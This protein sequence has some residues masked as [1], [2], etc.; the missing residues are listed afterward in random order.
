MESN[1]NVSS[2]SDNACKDFLLFAFCTFSDTF[3]LNLDLFHS[4]FP[5][6]FAS[7]DV[8]GGMNYAERWPNKDGTLCGGGVHRW[9][10]VVNDVKTFKIL[11]KS[12]N[13]KSFLNPE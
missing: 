5:L 6:Y 9:R 3:Q 8:D 12:L 13:F 2:L 10:Q 4:I 11:G 7:I 1:K